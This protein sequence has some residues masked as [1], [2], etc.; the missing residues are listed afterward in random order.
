[1][2]DQMYFDRKEQIREEHNIKRIERKSKYDDIKKKYGELPIS[3]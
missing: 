3:F 1:M 2:E